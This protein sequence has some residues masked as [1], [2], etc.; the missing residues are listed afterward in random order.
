MFFHLLNNQFGVL[1]F[2]ELNEIE[3]TAQY[4]NHMIDYQRCN[5]AAV[6]WQ[7]DSL[8][9]YNQF[10]ATKSMRIKALI[11]LIELLNETGGIVVQVC[12]NEYMCVESFC[13]EK[14]SINFI[15]FNITWID[16]FILY[17]IQFHEQQKMRKKI[18]TNKRATLC[19]IYRIFRSSYL[20]KIDFHFNISS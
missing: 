20:G 7:L 19:R 14:K 16:K 4:A 12:V 2:V 17:S 10:D 3:L 1:C 8:I 18:I 11:F 13:I 5:Q 6:Y 15:N 9:N